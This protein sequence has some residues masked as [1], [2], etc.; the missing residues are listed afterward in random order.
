MRLVCYSGGSSVER[1]LSGTACDSQQRVLMPETMSKLTAHLYH[2]TAFADLL[3]SASTKGQTTIGG[4]N[5]GFSVWW[6]VTCTAQKKVLAFFWFANHKLT[7]TWNAVHG[8]HWFWPMHHPFTLAVHSVPFSSVDYLRSCYPSYLNVIG[9]DR[10][11]DRQRQKRRR[12]Q[13][14]D[15]AQQLELEEWAILEKAKRLR[16][17]MYVRRAKPKNI[18]N[19]GAIFHF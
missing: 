10:D 5:G 1:S 8:L 6:Y 13:D 2:I 11:M 17:G 12:S 7:Y 4:A 14:L 9:I 15:N 18:D 16:I 3:Q 19:Q